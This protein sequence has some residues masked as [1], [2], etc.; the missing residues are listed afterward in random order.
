[1][2]TGLVGVIECRAKFMDQWD[3]RGGGARGRYDRFG[4]PGL[5]ILGHNTSLN[6]TFFFANASVITVCHDSCNTNI[7]DTD[8]IFT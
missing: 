6:V 1:M 7:E 8:A 4:H 5:G 2:R 3:E